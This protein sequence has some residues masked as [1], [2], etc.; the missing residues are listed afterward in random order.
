MTIQQIAANPIT[1]PPIPSEKKKRAT[2]NKRAETTFLILMLA[3]PLLQWLIFWLYVHLDSFALAFQDKRTGAFT[4]QNFESFW[5]M[6]TSP[7]GEIN[8]A[9]KNTLIYFATEIVILLPVSLLLSYFLYKKIF[10]YKGFRVIFYLPAIV[11][12]M[13]MVET[14]TS[15]ISPNGPIAQLVKLFGWEIPPQGLLANSDTATPTIVVYCIWTGF[16]G[17]V[18][19]FGSAMARVPIEVLESARLEGCG[20]LRELVQLILPLIW[21]TISTQVIFTCTGVFN[22]SG[23]I[24]LFTNGAYETETLSYWIF[25][26]V[27]GGGKYGGSGNYNIVSATGLCFTLVG[28]P[29]ILFIRWLFDKIP[30]VEY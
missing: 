24:L 17:N 2:S 21:P 18:L 19:L 4:F 1:E 3:L 5:E 29:I 10:L 20:P 26:Q 13:V 11:S 16:C 7:K 6:L 22:S 23:P 27:Y 28:V 8:I 15:F 9:L 12:S 30:T 14:Y 25:A